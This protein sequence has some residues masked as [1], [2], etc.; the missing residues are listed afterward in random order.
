MAE[1]QESPQKAMPKTQ[2]QTLFFLLQKHNLLSKVFD[3]T[4]SRFTATKYHNNRITKEDAKQ[5]FYLNC[6]ERN[7]KLKVDTNTKDGMKMLSAYAYK[8]SLNSIYSMLRKEAYIVSA[9]YS[10]QLNTVP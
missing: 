3:I 6:L 8:C 2:N 7:V 5:Q 4:W 10:E 9:S 1:I